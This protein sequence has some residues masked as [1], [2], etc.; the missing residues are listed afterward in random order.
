MAVKRKAAEEAQRQLKRIQLSRPG[1]EEKYDDSDAD[2][3]SS[4]IVDEVAYSDDELHP[5]PLT[6]FSPAS[7]KY[8]SELKTHH[9]PYDNCS[10]AFNRPAR[11]AEHLR[12]HTNERIFACTYDGCEKNFLRASHLNHHVKSAHTLVRDY[13][14]EREGCGKA[15]A[16]GSR[17]RR[18]LA[19]H[20]GRDKY[21]CTETGE[22]GRECGETFRKHSTLLK[23]VMMVHLKKRPFPCQA[24]LGSGKTCTAAFDTAG[25]LKAHERRVHGEA[26]FT[27]TECMSVDEEAEG[28]NGF[29]FPTYALLQLHMRSVHP[30]TCPSCAHTCSSAKDLRRHMEISHGTVSVDDRRTHPCQHPGCGRSFTKKGNLNVHVKTVH[31]GEKRFACGETDL[32]TS[33][34]VEGWDGADACGKRYGSK[35]ALEEHVRTAHMGYRNARAE[36]KAKTPTSSKSASASA[37]APQGPSNVAL[38]T[39]QGYAEESVNRQIPCLLA[40]CEHRFRRDYDLWLHMGTK[41]GMDENEVQILFMQRAMQGGNESFAR[42]AFEYEMDMMCG[43]EGEG[44]GD[45]GDG[46]RGRG[47]IDQGLYAYP[48][49]SVDEVMASHDEDQER[50]D[51]RLGGL[52]GLGGLVDPLLT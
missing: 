16:T 36:R 29:S 41:H 38:L 10:K 22:G 9:C 27:C 13:V 45:G 49:V 51:D 44:E 33:K 4:S 18:H 7:S 12:S 11:L 24:V 26:R 25:H 43:N 6:P 39:G 32:S 50:K 5:T 42:P 23:H 1:Q 17:L 28:G 35:L 48:D 14:C 15:F 19:A 46:G 47:H 2:C 20:E 3:D 34:K 37:S 40:E 31:E 21:T 30:P 8:P 52:G